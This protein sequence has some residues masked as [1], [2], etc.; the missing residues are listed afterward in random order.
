MH[1]LISALVL[2]SEA[3]LASDLQNIISCFVDTLC[4]VV[5]HSE[6]Q[7]AWLP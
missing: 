3:K 5:V 1:C 4:S 7:D 6:D 2:S